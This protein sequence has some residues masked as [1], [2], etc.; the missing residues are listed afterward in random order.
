MKSSIVFRAVITFCLLIMVGS[1]LGRIIVIDGGPPGVDGFGIRYARH[2]LVTFLHIVPGIL[3]LVLAPLQ[4]VSRIRGSRPQVHRWLGRLLLVCGGLSGI[5]ALLLGVRLPAFG[6]L[7]TQVATF[8]F[9][10]TFLVCLGSAYARIRQW[11]VEAHRAWM[12][13]A[14]AL[15]LAVATVRITTAVLTLAFALPY[16]VAFGWSFWIGFSLNLALAELWI[17]TT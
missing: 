17:R 11:Q 10:I 1:T 8:V 9:G 16:P 3:F 15:G 7:T 6:G 13:R 14:F 2:P 4:F 12:I 5:G